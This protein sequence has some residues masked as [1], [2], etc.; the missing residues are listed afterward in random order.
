MGAKDN[1]DFRISDVFENLDGTDIYL[2][3]EFRWS[4]VGPVAKSTIL[5]SML[6]ALGSFYIF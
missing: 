1:S 5:T 2:C 6:G 4:P 3:D